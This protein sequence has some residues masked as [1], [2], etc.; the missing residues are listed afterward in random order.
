MTSAAALAV[1][2]E[3]R[4]GNAALIELLPLASIEEDPNQPRKVFQEETLEE[5]AVNIETTAGDSSQPWI[6][7]LLHPVTV[8]S[9]PSWAEGSAGPQWRLLTGARRLRT[10]R[11]RRW[12][13]IPARV[14]PV[15]E[16]PFRALLIQ[17]NENL[18][19]EDTSLWEDATAVERALVLWRFEHP[20]KPT[21][22]FAEKLGRSPAW[23]SHR[24]ML[25]RA[26]GVARQALVEKRIASVE[27]YR[28]FVRLT[29]QVQ[30]QLLERVRRSCEPITPSLLKPHLPRE[31]P[32]GSPAAGEEPARPARG[33]PSE[34]LPTAE[35]SALLT[36]EVTLEQARFLLYLLN[37]PIPEEPG[38]VT[39]ALSRAL[40]KIEA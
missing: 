32:M 5:L 12:P 24:L 30:I 15:P 10:Y 39:A 9:S 2:D 33:V 25:A 3:A 8:Y 6:D 19:R 11:L 29:P 27:A 20:K 17:M 4:S 28:S 26:T 13:A 22:E 31:R 37:H 14:V 36:L 21:R 38:E 23:V 35:G 1:D 40:A 34:D 7:G 16:S 18:G